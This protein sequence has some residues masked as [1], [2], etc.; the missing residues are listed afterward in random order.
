[1]RQSFFMYH[2]WYFFFQHLRPSPWTLKNRCESLALLCRWFIHLDQL[3]DSIQTTGTQSEYNPGS[4]TKQFEQ[5]PKVEDFQS[6]AAAEVLFTVLWADISM[7]AGFLYNHMLLAGHCGAAG[8]SICTI[9]W[10]V[11]YRCPGLSPSLPDPPT[12]ILSLFII[13]LQQ[14]Q[15][16]KDILKEKGQHAVNGAVDEDYES[17]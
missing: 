9:S 11:P 8:F 5:S 14:R 12:H 1:M 15:R 13:P 6:T 17:G 10:Q 3:I 2:N 4:Q 7:V 16:D